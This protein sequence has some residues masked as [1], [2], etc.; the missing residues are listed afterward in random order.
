MTW[1]GGRSKALT[2]CR[3]EKLQ[4][5]T[6]LRYKRKETLL[7]VC[8]SQEKDADMFAEQVEGKSGTL[9]AQ[10]ISKSNILRKRY[11]EKMS[12]VKKVEAELVIEN[13][14]LKLN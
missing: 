10:L 6:S 7:D 1:K 3:R 8:E 14:Q 2:K 5:I 4:K 9:M 12:E 13:S 11:K